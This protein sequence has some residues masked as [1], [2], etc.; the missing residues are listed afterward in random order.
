MTERKQNEFMKKHEKD[1]KWL[2]E[3]ENHLIN[4][5]ARTNN[6]EL[7]DKF[8]EWQHQR[9]ICNDR[10]NKYLDE[11]ISESKQQNQK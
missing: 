8:E 5:I 10:Y 2:Q 11:L 3:I 9:G 7:M 4:L 6:D 1:V